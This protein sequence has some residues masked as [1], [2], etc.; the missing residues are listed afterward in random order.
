MLKDDQIEEFL[1]IKSRCGTKDY[2]DPEGYH[3]GNII[4]DS[5][6]TNIKY[7]K[8]Y[9]LCPMCKAEFENKRS[10]GVHLKDKV[11]VDHMWTP[12]MITKFLDRYQGVAREEKISRAD[13]F[14]FVVEPRE[15]VPVPSNVEVDLTKPMMKNTQPPT[16]AEREQ[17]DKEMILWR[18]AMKDLSKREE[19]IPSQI[20]K[21]GFDNAGA[22]RNYWY[23]K[24]EV[25]RQ[26]QWLGI[27]TRD[28]KNWRSMKHRTLKLWTISTVE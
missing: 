4:V 15:I 10:L 5:G 27:S 24:P 3:K 9:F 20:H 8:E 12:K 6:V 1:R 23:W 17:H 16:P 13:I 28:L 19:I 21:D 26:G 2:S 22:S 11:D 7:L 14:Y 18:I 25:W